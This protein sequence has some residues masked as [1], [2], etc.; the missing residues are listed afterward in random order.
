MVIFYAVAAIVG[1]IIGYF[2]TSV[3]ITR[4]GINGMFVC[5]RYS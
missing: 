2:L 1:R 4:G 5:L 3:K